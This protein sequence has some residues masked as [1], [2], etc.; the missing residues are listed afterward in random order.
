MSL[1]VG[2]VQTSFDD[3]QKILTGKWTIKNF[4]DYRQIIKSP[5]F[6]VDAYD[7]KWYLRITSETGND[8]WVGLG[9]EPSIKANFKYTLAL[10]SNFVTGVKRFERA[11]RDLV[12]HT[13]FGTRDQILAKRVDAN[14]SLEV[15]CKIS[16]NDITFTDQFYH[17]TRSGLGRDLVTTLDGMYTDV[18]FNVGGEVI[19]A[20][21]VI[22][23]SRCRVF[24]AMFKMDTDEARTGIVTIEDIAPEV[25]RGML[26]YIYTGWCQLDTMDDTINML[27]AADKYNLVELIT[28]C[29]NHIF[30]NMSEDNVV[31]VLLTTDFIESIDIRDKCLRLLASTPHDQI[32][33]LDKVF[34]NPTLTKLINEHGVPHGPDLSPDANVH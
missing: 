30:R 21:K 20:H 13:M 34:L 8:I 28:I 27:I 31:S 12:E 9:S 23:T 29:K 24:A 17:W 6:G 2:Q 25:F 16:Y 14:G 33:D 26:T 15:F 11:E 18:Q 22:I 7:M 1:I 5:M 10:D 4:N 32:P 19:K 3:S